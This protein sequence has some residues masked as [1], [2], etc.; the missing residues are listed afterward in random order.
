MM[1][2]QETESPRRDG[3]IDWHKVAQHLRVEAETL[4]IYADYT[5]SNKDQWAVTAALCEAVARALEMGFKDDAVNRQ[6]DSDSPG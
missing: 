6:A 3:F 1:G 2:D 5:N 4:S